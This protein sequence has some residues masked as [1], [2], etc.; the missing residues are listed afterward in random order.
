MFKDNLS[1]HGCILLLLMVSH[2]LFADDVIRSS[3]N[4]HVNWS[5][6]T[7]SATGYGVAGDDVPDRKKRIL[8]RRA[9]QL[10]AYRN[11]AEMLYGVR[12]TSE[13]LVVEMVKESDTVKTKLES[14]V[15]GAQITQE[16]YQ[17]EVATVTLVMSLDGSFIQ[18]IIPDLPPQNT[19]V[20][21]LID[22]NSLLAEI[23]RDGFDSLPS[24]INKAHAAMQNEKL[25]IEN[26]T[27]LELAKKIKSMLADSS[28]EDIMLFLSQQID[29]YQSDTNFT[30]LLVD[31]T[32]ISNFQLATIPRL[33]TATGEIIYPTDLDL[34]AGS[35]T[36]RP[37]SY[38]FDLKD[39]INNQ[40]VAVKPLVIKALGVYKSR[41]SD[42]V[43]SDSDAQIIRTHSAII[44]ALNEAGV[45]IVVAE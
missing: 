21:T 26:N 31:A 42:L 20:Q 43:I 41:Q 8:A 5:T 3:A 19:L 11:L 38:D 9:A 4:G 13:T 39:A 40:R 18:T 28:P 33:R 32:K 6:G 14:R 7:V 29:S 27:Q 1:R 44:K 37:V 25:R 17:N 23:M 30:G 34:K 10:D 45:M 12:V 2:S 36:K 35:M 24:L 15:K 22:T 16:N